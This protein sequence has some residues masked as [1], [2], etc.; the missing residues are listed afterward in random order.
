[1]STNRASSTEISSQVSLRVTL[2]QD[3]I[4]FAEPGN[5]DSIK[6]ADFGLG[7]KYGLKND[8]ALDAHC[9]TLIFMAPE[10]IKS[11]EYTKKVDIFSIGI[12]MY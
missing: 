3:N 5:L 1:M 2:F 12:I 8:S 4:L 6:I 11:K 9:G 10:V 7:A